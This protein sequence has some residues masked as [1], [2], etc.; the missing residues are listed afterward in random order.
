M[1]STDNWFRP[2]NFVNAPDG[3]LYILDMYRETIEHPFSI[4]DDIKAHLD[5]KAVSTAAEFIG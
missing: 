2:V 4:P 5:L 3:T 1:T